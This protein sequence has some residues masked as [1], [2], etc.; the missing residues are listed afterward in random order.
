MENSFGDALDNLTPYYT[1]NHLRPNPDKTQLC[2]FHLR[3]RE[4]NRQLRVAWHGKN[5]QHVRNPIYLGVSLDRS[6]TYKENSLK[7][8]AKVESRNNT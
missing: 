3:N 1:K 2:A 5:L 7:T 4:A 8:Y 6:L